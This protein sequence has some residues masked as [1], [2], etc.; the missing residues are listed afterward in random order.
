M[1]LSGK[2]AIVTGGGRDIGSACAIRLA[3]EG[4]NV[5][6]NY[7]AS[8]DRAHATVD[9]ITAAGGQAIAVQGDLSKPDGVDALV[10]KAVETY[11]TV[12]I[13]VNNT[14]GLIARSST[15]R[16]LVT[17]PLALSTTAAF[18]TTASGVPERTRHSSRTSE[19]T[20][21]TASPPWV[22]MP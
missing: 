4:A 14:G 16:D 20:A 18:L 13:L 1:T 2:T 8:A 9:A 7:F 3:R 12:D 6:I 19:G 15:A 17:H 10:A 5:V 11:G 21:L 22:M